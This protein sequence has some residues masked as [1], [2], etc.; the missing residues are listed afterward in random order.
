G[1]RLTASWSWLFFFFQAEDGI[2]DFHVTGV[3]TCALPILTRTT[4][5]TSSRSPSSATSTRASR[6]PRRTSSSSASRHSRAARAHCSWPEIGRA[7]CRERGE[8]RVVGAGS[9]T[10]DKNEAD[11]R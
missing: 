4:R 5:R 8:N 10:K 9:E 3:Q 11:G 6:T 2:R 7:S 1:G